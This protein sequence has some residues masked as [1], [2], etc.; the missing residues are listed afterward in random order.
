MH[1][2]TGGRKSRSDAAPLSGA[3]HLSTV[4]RAPNFL[5]IGAPRAGTTWIERNLRHHPEVFLPVRKELHFFDR[6]ENFARGIEHYRAYFDDADQAKAVG[7]ATPDYLHH[8]LAPT[9]IKAHLGDVKLIVSL[10]DPVERAYSRY[11]NSRG[12]FAENAGLT[13]EEKLERKPQFIYEGYYF[14]H[15]SRYL[16]LFDRSRLLCLLFDDLKADGAAFMRTVYDFLEIDPS[17]A[18]AS[19]G[20]AVNAAASKKRNGKSRILFYLRGAASRLKLETLADKLDAANRSPIP[21]VDPQTRRLLLREHYLPQIE[22]LE[23][24]LG[25]DLGAWKTGA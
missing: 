14:D 8:P 15:L 7:E 12:K 13:F 3:H 19:S 22:A 1:V 5:V 21:P 16:E 18:A 11:W 25:R 24:L 9:R 20:S 6:D 23:D 10:R 2:V 17:P 4:K